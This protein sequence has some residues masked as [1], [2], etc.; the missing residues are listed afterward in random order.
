[1]DQRVDLSGLLRPFIAWL[2]ERY[3]EALGDSQRSQQDVGSLKEAYP[4]DN[5]PL[6][7]VQTSSLA[8]EVGDVGDVVV[9]WR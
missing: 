2:R 9:K 5:Q 7:E 6:R 3:P 4:I 1:M 8:G